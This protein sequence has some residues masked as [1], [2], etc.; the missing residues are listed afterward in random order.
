MTPASLRVFVL[1][2]ALHASAVAP[3]GQARLAPPTTLAVAGASNAYASL[4]SEGQLVA[5]AWGATR[6]VVTDVY[7]AVSRDGG[8][9]FS[10]PRQ[11]SDASSLAHLSGEQPP[12]VVLVPRRGASP[13]IVAVW[14]TKTPAGTRLMVVRS[15][16]AGRTFTRPRVVVGS[17]AP[18]NRGWHSLAVTREG[19]VVVVWLDHRGLSADRRRSGAATQEHEHAGRAT[20]SDGEARAQLSKLLVAVLGDEPRTHAITGGVCYCCKTSVA[21]GPDGALYAAWRHVYAGNLRDV[22][23]AVSSDRGRTFS[24]PARVSEDGWAIDGCP[25]NGPAVSVDGRRRAYVAWPT[26]VTMPG[27]R[28]PSM[29]LFLSSSTDAQRFTSRQRILAE[30]VARHPQMATGLNGHVALVW[31]EEGANA[32]RRVAFA[33]GTPASDG[34]AEFTRRVLSDGVRSAYPVIASSG[35]E[36]LV[37]WTSGAPT[38]SKIRVRRLVP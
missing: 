1:S 37:A 2:L 30:G 19:E 12:R 25:E 15:D 3:I 20:N 14:T 29:A 32:T 34:T 4:A 11:L 10:P 5:L 31:D 28:E 9:S 16:D 26:V 36:F 33:A 6:S 23:V 38:D 8:R 18:G 21:A 17:E 35:G 13:A 22:A 27:D 7:L 24:T